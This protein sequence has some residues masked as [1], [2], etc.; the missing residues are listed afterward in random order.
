M[1][2]DDDSISLRNG[3]RLPAQNR[4]LLGSNPFLTTVTATQTNTVLASVVSTV[5]TAVV[6]SCIPVAQFVA[7]AAVAA[8]PAAGANPAVAATP[9]TTSTQAC[10]RRRRDADYD[11]EA[12]MLALIEPATNPQP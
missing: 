3:N 2:D 4:F 7:V 5:T 11:V 1:I 8:V 10:S 12:A 9:A 6:A